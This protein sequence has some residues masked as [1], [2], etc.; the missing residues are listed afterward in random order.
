MKQMTIRCI[1]HVT[2]VPN[3]F[4]FYMIDGQIKEVTFDEIIIEHK[5]NRTIIYCNK[6]KANEVKPWKIEAIK[7]KLHGLVAYLDVYF[8]T[9]KYYVAFTEETIKQLNK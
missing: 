2:D 6:P 9:D 5:E 8:T 7:T 4:Y 3:T 1:G